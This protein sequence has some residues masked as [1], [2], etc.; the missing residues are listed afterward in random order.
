MLS[1]AIDFQQVQR[2]L[3]TKLRHH[4]DVLLASP[5]FSVLKN[6]APHLVIDAL[7]YE[8]TREMLEGHPSIGEVYTI[9]RRWKKRGVAHQMAREWA[10]LK[11]LRRNRYDVLI[12]L[13][14]HPRGAWLSR[15]LGVRFAVARKLSNA[16][17]LWRSSFTHY[18]PF[19]RNTPRH[20]V[21]LNLDAL[22]RIGVYPDETER[23]LTLV[24][25]ASAQQKSMGLLHDFGLNGADYVHIHPTSR[26]MFKTWPSGA[27]AEV[28]AHLQA[29][30]CTVVLTAGPDAKERVMVDQI[31][32]LLKAPVLDLAGKLSL[33]QLAVVAAEA[34]LFIGV[35]SAPM[36]IAAAM[37][38]PVIALFGP[39]GEKEWGPW[40]VVHRVIASDHPCRPCG[41]DGCGGGKR[42]ECLTTIP[43]ARVIEAID[44][45]L[46]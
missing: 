26:W 39:S 24:T 9:D 6:H 4:G 31:L 41:N 35:D 13:T 21:E 46:P 25:S 38:T 28:I 36:H 22:R 5:V 32:A 27:F 37:Q 19:P 1:D 16:D 3:V 8:E 34:R 12:H 11:A 40:Q 17:V 45:L 42:S 2:V 30:G 20:T 33:K 18:Y 10:L 14:E 44:A 15:L 43:A 7:V 29:R 23:R